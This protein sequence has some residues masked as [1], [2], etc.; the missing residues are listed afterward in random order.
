MRCIGIDPGTVSIDLVGLDGGEL[1]L[2]RSIPTAD[3]LAEPGAFAESLRELH[4]V[5]IA[6]PS[7]YGLPLTRVE[8]ATDELLRLAYLAPAGENGGIGGLRALARA[9]ADARLPVLFTP[10]VLHLPSVPAYRKINRVDMGTADKVCAAALAIHDQA[11]RRGCGY[12]DVSFVLLELGGAF[13]AAIA[14]SEGRI[15]DGLGGTAGPLGLRAAGALDGEVAFLAGAIGKA[16]LF[17]GGVAS[18]IGGDTQ[19]LDSLDTPRTDRDRLA[20]DAFLESAV[21]A[22]ASL[23][24]SVPH[25]HEILLS[26]RATHLA[27]V[28][29]ALR[30]RLSP[31]G[32]VRRLEGFARTAKEAAQGAAL[33]ADGLA[34]GRYEALVTRMGLREAGGTVLD[35]LHLISPAAA[36]QR[37]GIA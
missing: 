37:L 32:A 6:G 5:L 23:M 14:V 27:G 34:G 24:V 12:G 10:G 11:T 29:R 30:L 1:F 17:T 13:S 3:A 9:L 7:G 22:V 15:V 31:Y 26:G 21:K 18:I 36:R 33:I 4:A 25:P 28:E 35:H 8:D 19:P 2:D 20:R 16:L